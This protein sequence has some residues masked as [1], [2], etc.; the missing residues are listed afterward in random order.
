MFAANNRKLVNE[1][2][3]PRECNQFLHG[4]GKQYEELLSFLMCPFSHLC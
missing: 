3:L 2:S 4:P 1:S